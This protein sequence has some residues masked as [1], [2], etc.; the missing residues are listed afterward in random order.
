MHCSFLRPCC[1]LSLVLL[2]CSPLS[3]VFVSQGNGT[4]RCLSRFGV[5]GSGLSRAL[6]QWFVSLCG[7][8]SEIIYASLP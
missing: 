3:L 7:I 6:L 8:V 4:S 1:H 2:Q 5:S